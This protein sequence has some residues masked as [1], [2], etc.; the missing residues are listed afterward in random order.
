[1][2]LVSQLEHAANS[3]PEN[4]TCLAYSRGS[5]HYILTSTEPPVFNSLQSSP[6]YNLKS[7]LFQFTFVSNTLVKLYVIFKTFDFFFFNCWNSVPLVLKI[8]RTWHFY[9]FYCKASLKMIIFKTCKNKSY[10]ITTLSIML[11]SPAIVSI[12]IESHVLK[13]TK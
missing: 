6:L 2:K 8:L 11:S 5:S 13:G 3:F 9:S 4:S 7:K 10:L 1:M 12:F